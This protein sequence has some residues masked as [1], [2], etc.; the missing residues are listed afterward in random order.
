MPENNS[1]NGRLDSWKEIADYLKRDVRTAIRSKR[2]DFLS[3]VFR[4]ES[5]K[6]FLPTRMRLMPG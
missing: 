2:G 3:I 1:A 6:Q 5:G 4:E